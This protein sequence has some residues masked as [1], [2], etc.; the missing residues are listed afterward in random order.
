MVVDVC[1]TQPNICLFTVTAMEIIL[2]KK[3]ILKYIIKF[4]SLVS[5]SMVIL[6]VCAEKENL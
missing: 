4:G 2:F 3:M 5:I 1:I 6:I